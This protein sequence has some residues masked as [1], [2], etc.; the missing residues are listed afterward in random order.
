MKSSDKDFGW[1]VVGA[2]F[3]IAAITWGVGLYGITTL[4]A[5]L[6]ESKGWSTATLSAAI[7]LHYLTSALLTFLLARAHV[8]LGISRVTQIGA[9]V[10]AVG[11]V[12]W[13][14]AW[15]PWHL[16]IAALLSGCGWAAT[17]TT[18]IT[19]MVSAWFDHD[20]PRALGVAMNGISVGGLL[21]APVWPGLI[22]SLGVSKASLAIGLASCV[23][24]CVLAQIFL[25]PVGP[26][27]I[28]TLR[29]EN[30]GSL[31]WRKARVSSTWKFQS[32]AIS[33][34]IGLLAVMGIFIHL[35]AYLAEIWG[36]VAAGLTIGLVTISTIVGRLLLGWSLHRVD[37]RTAAALCFLLTGAGSALLTATQAPAVVLVGCI[38][39]GLGG[40]GLNLLPPLIAQREYA[41][42]VTPT[43]V[44][45]LGSTNQ[46]ALTAAPVTIGGLTSLLGAYR[47]PFLCAV[48]L[49]IIAALL[50]LTHSQHP[51]RA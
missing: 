2:V 18:A 29:S 20:R 47:G 13:A 39:F 28:R 37:L 7:S 5:A 49:Q 15:L 4:L 6:K 12:A 11:I 27:A 44:A 45:L 46:L 14:H 36:L 16:A 50:I 40:A 3:V 26:H 33:F 32:V 31:Q 38:L 30:S 42:D 35:T 24:I 43:V 51:A 17:G 21:F 23:I 22:Y 25:T 19:A 41:A 1:K 10:M 48:I 34:A 8:A 9:L